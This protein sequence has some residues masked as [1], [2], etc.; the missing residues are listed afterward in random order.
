MYKYVQCE[1]QR[2]T[3]LYVYVYKWKTVQVK[4]KIKLGMIH[5]HY[6]K[7]GGY[8]IKTVGICLFKI[9]FLY[10]YTWIL[11]GI[12]SGKKI[13]SILNIHPLSWFHGNELNKERNMITFILCVQCLK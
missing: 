4:W 6:Q 1:G 3:T 13:V 12:L 10:I 2:G 9:W 8:T 11:R 7:I 5:R